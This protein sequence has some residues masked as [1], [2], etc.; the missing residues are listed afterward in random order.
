MLLDVVLS[1]VEK[2]LE[3]GS[4]LTEGDGDE[5]HRHSSIIIFFDQVVPRLLPPLNTT[6]P[7]QAPGSFAEQLWRVA[8][9]DHE[10]L[11]LRIITLLAVRLIFDA[12]ACACGRVC[13]CATWRQ[14]FL[15]L[16]MAGQAYPSRWEVSMP[17]L[18]QLVHDVAQ[19]MPVR[20]AALAALSFVAPVMCSVADGMTPLTGLSPAADL[21][22]RL[23]S[24]YWPEP[25]RQLVALLHSFL[26]TPAGTAAPFAMVVV[27][28][29][30]VMTVTV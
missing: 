12:C 16:V 21:D 5:D 3:V 13:A 27:M 8:G 11:R 22:P 26:P 7:V 6:R 28:V 25:A 9:A 30:V 4:R 1:E 20:A 19:T 24:S 2:S 17:P 15:P 14:R 18:T 29:M 10:S 23:G